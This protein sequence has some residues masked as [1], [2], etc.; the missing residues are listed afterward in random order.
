[1]IIVFSVS[2][3]VKVLNDD[4]SAEK[5]KLVVNAIIAKDSLFTVNVSR[6][7]NIFDDESLNHLPF[8][9]DAVVKVFKNGSYL[10]TLTPDTLGYYQ[11][12]FY[13]EQGAVYSLEISA[14]SFEAVSCKTSLPEK[15]PID[16]WDTVSVMDGNGEYSEINYYGKVS[17]KD[18]ENA[19]NFYALRATIY[20]ETSFGD[21]Y[22]D[23]L[24]LD[25]PEGEQ[26]LFDVGDGY[27]LLWSDKF[28]NGKEINVRFNYL[29]WY[30]GYGKDVS[31]T[32]V[33]TIYL[34][35]LTYDYYSFL[36]TYTLY[37]ETYNS[38]P[39]MEPV[40]IHNNVTN[41]YGIFGA[42]S[43]DSVSFN[44]VLPRSGLRKGGVR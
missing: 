4:L 44:L 29:Q 2:G 24:W 16:H 15:I 13:P 18:P 7:F 20:L 17:L 33:I 35:T 43:E 26:E 23:Q 19:D 6:T 34:R 42:Y 3:C 21:V 27:Q 36:K 10:A 5:S 32:A 41:G 39:F 25:V 40:V 1:L 38:D 14:E 11:G 9:E 22:T 37:L 31:D 8:V 28:L 30:A 12:N